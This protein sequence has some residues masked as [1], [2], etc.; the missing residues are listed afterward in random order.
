MDVSFDVQG[1]S[2]RIVEFHLLDEANRTLVVL[3]RAKEPANDL[4][5]RNNPD[6]QVD[7]NEF[8][9]QGSTLHHAA[10]AKMLVTLSFHA[11]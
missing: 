2:R 10:L 8:Q 9:L 3:R 1:K 11:P 5:Y 6:Y 4:D 7:S